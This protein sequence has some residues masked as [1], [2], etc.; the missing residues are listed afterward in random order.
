M[1]DKYSEEKILFKGWNDHLFRVCGGGQI[2][3]NVTH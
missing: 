3:K 1:T 2:K